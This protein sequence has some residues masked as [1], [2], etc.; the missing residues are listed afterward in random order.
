MAIK[1][2]L[3]NGQRLGDTLMMTP[4]VRDLA[5][6]YPQYKI[7]VE[8]NFPQIW[9]N[10]PYIETYRQIIRDQ[11]IKDI[12]DYDEKYDI[13]P[14]IVTQGSRT[15]GQHFTTAFRVCL[16]DRLKRQIKQGLLKPEI[17]L[18][19]FEKKRRL[20]NGKY[21]LINLGYGQYQA[22]KWYNERW[23]EVVDKLPWIKFV[24]VGLKDEYKLKNVIDLL[25]KTQNPYA[26]L[27][28]LFTLFYHCEGVIT[29][30]TASMH[31]AASF[32]KPCIVIAGAREPVTFESYQNHRYL[33]NI[34]CLPCSDKYACWKCSLEACNNR[35]GGL[36]NGH[37]KCMDMIKSDDVIKAVESYYEGGILKKPEFKA[38]INVDK[39]PIF[40]I[41]CNAHSWGG[42]EKS[43]AEI[44]KMALDKG[45]EV[46]L[47]SLK[48]PCEPFKRAVPYVY[49]TKEIT[50]PCDILFMYAS[51][52]V[53][54]FDKPEFDVFKNLKAK[55]KCMALT[56]K[57]GKTWNYNLSWTKDWDLYL[58]LSADK[59]NELFKK[60]NPNYEATPITKVLAP[61]V[62][63]EPFYKIQINYNNAIHILRHSS[64][65]DIKYSKDINEIVNKFQ[66]HVMFSF[67]PAPSFLLNFK[68]TFKYKYN[69]ISVA[70]FLNKGNC[71]WYLLPSNYEDQG[72]RVIMEAMAAGLPIIAE[73]RDGAKDRLTEEC[74]WLINN[75][76]KAIDIINSLTPRILAEKGKA[77]RKRAKKE[78]KKEKWIETIIGEIE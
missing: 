32:D 5:N 78:F 67:M 6:N 20:I 25:G 12:K 7:H 44:I 21:W 15:N 52:M 4:A 64:Q 30:V 11:N 43:S 58:F 18:S 60:V 40:K 37:P 56:Y 34:G 46:Q 36:I 53:Y 69:E 10:N 61:P 42:A 73:N 16:E 28:D 68:N 2:L 26:G 38:N 1:L 23:Q 45:Y 13:G 55:R 35:S 59:R 76:K 31:I 41:I 49:Y 9:D 17:Y 51:D 77:A 75:H 65:G 27:R 33:H 22:K 63:L 66:T 74:G 57:I 29:L 50:R 14:K 19:E 3:R 72:P 48:Q 54:S 70:E 62:D 8:T 71:Y 24:Q 47:A 39:K